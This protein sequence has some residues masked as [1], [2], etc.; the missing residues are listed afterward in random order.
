MIESIQFTNFKALRQTTLPLSPFTLLLGPNGS[1][2]SSVL[3]A[4]QGIAKGGLAHASFL[5]VTTQDR[6]APVEIQLWMWLNGQ[7]D[8][9]IYQWFT[10]GQP[11]PRYNRDKGVAIGKDE[12]N[13]IRQWLRAT[14]R[15]SVGRENCP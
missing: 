9:G 15:M 8:I 7:R 10:T 2:K 4:I 3:Q 5:S 13:K 1:G 11:N 14:N 12:I 6:A